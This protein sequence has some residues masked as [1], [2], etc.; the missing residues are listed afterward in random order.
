MTFAKVSFLVILRFLNTG[1]VSSFSINMYS[2]EYML[3]L[4][5]NLQ[6]IV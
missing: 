6:L 4:T 5:M 3:L 2:L 1:H